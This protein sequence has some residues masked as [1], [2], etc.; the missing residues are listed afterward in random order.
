MNYRRHSIGTTL[1]VMFF[2]AGAL[3]C[4]V[5]ILALAF[6]GG[7]LEPIWRLKPDARLEFQHIG[8]WSVV[9]MAVV[10]AACGLAAVGLARSAEWGRRLAIGVLTVNL[11]GDSLNAWLRHDPRTLVGLPIGGLMIWYLARRSCARGD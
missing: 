8:I 10:G 7:F 2:A 11:I 4:L 6:P 9:L 3:I 5:T 1:L